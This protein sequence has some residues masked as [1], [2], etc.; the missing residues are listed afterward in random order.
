MNKIALYAVVALAPLLCAATVTSGHLY[1]R[2]NDGVYTAPGK[3][4]RLTSPFPDQPVVSDGQEPA[5]NK[6][7]AVSFI[8]SAGRMQGVLYMNNK[9]YQAAEGAGPDTKLLGDWFRDMGFPRFFQVSVPD[10]KVLRDEA[11]RIADQPAWI[12]VAHVPNGSPLGTPIK[13]SYDL[14]RNDSYRGMAVVARG[15]RYYLLQ[16]ELRIEKLA[17]PEWFYDEEAA[18]WNQFIPELEALYQRIEFLK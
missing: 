6:A 16:T 18:N 15:D 10:A 5:N 13:D 14:K 8:D 12:A 17:G 11:G 4:F 3:L 9:G 1:G 2:Y 7:G